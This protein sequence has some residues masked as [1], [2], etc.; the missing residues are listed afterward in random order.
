MKRGCIIIPYY[1]QWPTYLRL[2]LKTCKFNRELTI[3]IFTDLE[4]PE[5]FPD[6]VKLIHFTFQEL[7]SSLNRLVSFETAIT[8]P[9][10][11]CD[12]RPAYGLIFEK[13]IRDF[14]FWGWGDL[15]VLY[16]SLRDAELPA[17]MENYDVI[18]FRQK[19]FSGSLCFIKNI[20]F[21]K[22]LFLS[23][24][25]L[26]AVLT[27]PEYKGF[28]EISLCWSQIMTV[29]FERIKWPYDNFTQMILK[30]QHDHGLHTYFAN[31]IK[32]SIPANGYLIWENGRIT[33]NSG[34]TFTHY[35]FITEKRNPWFE[36]PS[37]RL[38]PDK[39]FITQKGFF[40]EEEFER[41]NKIEFDRWLSAIPKV[42]ANFGKRVWSKIRVTK[43]IE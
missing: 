19:W 27:T 33:D 1:G 17:L 25:D 26:R 39:F 12:V 9:Y 40:T 15:D 10:K 7:V 37:W 41:K 22:Q 24:P 30:A 28:D 4:A 11:L 3:L 20:D 38:V 23:S 35:H 34:C 29:P 6:N 5:L 14:D 32:E 13:Y 2:Y 31:H 16:G 8:T 43:S 42:I 18:S 36:Y 21:L